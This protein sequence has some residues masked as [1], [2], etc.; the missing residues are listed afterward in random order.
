RTLPT[1][2]CIPRQRSAWL[3][4]KYRRA[5]WPPCSSR[6]L[7]RTH[8]A[9]PQRN[10]VGC[11]LREI[12]CRARVR[13]APKARRRASP[14]VVLDPILDRGVRRTGPYGYRAIDLTAGTRQAMRELLAP[15]GARLAS[16]PTIR[17]I[18]P[19]TKSLR[20][21]SSCVHLNQAARPLGG[22]PGAMAALHQRGAGEEEQ[23]L[24]V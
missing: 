12:D 19:A 23:V 9:A 22:R 20:V 16:R 15:G 1:G 18:Q 7:P 11:A 6:S 4:S 2:E 8:P 21:L 10:R 17:R 14:P 5:R 3:P 13:G 24:R